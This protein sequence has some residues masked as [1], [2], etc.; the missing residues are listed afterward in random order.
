MQDIRKVIEFFPKISQISNLILSISANVCD[1]CRQLPIDNLRE[2]KSFN[3]F[4]FPI[5]AKVK[6]SLKA[7]SSSEQKISRLPP[8]LI[9]YQ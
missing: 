7:S 1:H 9:N 3:L 8:A 2:Q 6:Q 5:I 4:N